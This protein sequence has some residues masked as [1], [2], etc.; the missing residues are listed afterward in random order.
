MSKAGLG[1]LF[2]GIH[3]GWNPEATPVFIVDQRDLRT[4]RFDE[5]MVVMGANSR[6]EAA[7]VYDRHFSDGRG[8]E[9]RLGGVEMSLSEFKRWLK[10]GDTTKP[11]ADQRTRFA[12]GSIAVST[13]PRLPEPLPAETSSDSVTSDYARLFGSRGRHA[14]GAS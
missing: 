4:H 2:S 8:P 11:A 10:E 12:G 1:G 13:F 9:R 5:P 7:A 3:T 6:A 14:A